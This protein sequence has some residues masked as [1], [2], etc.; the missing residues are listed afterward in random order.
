V[1]APAGATAVAAARRP[2][3]WMR[4][5][6][7]AWLSSVLAA[8][9]AFAALRDR[10][11]DDARF[12]IPPDSLAILDREGRLLRHERPLLDVPPEGVLS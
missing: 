7:A 11:I 8:G 12:A 2:R 6:A 10:L 1:S 5:L 3:P 4:R 9:L